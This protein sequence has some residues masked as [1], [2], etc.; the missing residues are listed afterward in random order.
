MLSA[1]L[2]DQASGLR[3]L[4]G[5]GAPFR[6]CGF[7]GPDAGL[8]AAAAAS[9][10]SALA[11]RGEAVLILDEAE[12]PRNVASQFGLAPRLRLADVLQGRCALDRA[13]AKVGAGVR[14]LAAGQ[15][16]PA[17][18]LA[19]EEAW[20]WFL[21]AVNALDEPPGWVIVNAPAAQSAPALAC[22]CPDRLLVVPDRKAVL[23]EAYT[24]LKAVHQLYPD[25]HWRMLAMNSAGLQGNN[26]L[27]TALASTAQR[28]LGVQLDW[29]GAVP[30]DE[31]LVH[32]T[33]VMKPLLEVSPDCPAALA[34]KGLAETANAWPREGEMNAEAFWQRLYL[35]GRLAAETSGR[36]MQ[37][38]VLGRRY[39]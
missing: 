30:K 12:S 21:D 32:S 20:D 34:F 35:L 16:L 2:Q 23:T 38:A 7:F 28:F 9:L 24:V 10:A 26:G 15:S 27:Y 19:S 4:L 18:A 6:S 33:R 3:R 22:G 1:E 29:F 11:R 13:L 39:G 17:L 36:S 37:N 31:K 25:G 14:L 8:K 5:S